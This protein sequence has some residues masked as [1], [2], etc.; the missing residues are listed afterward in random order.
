M[1]EAGVTQVDLAARLKRPQPFISYIESGERRV[2]LIEF[3]AIAKAL[4]VDPQALFALV[5]TRLPDHVDI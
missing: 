4:G 3:Y 2:D 5:V 1:K